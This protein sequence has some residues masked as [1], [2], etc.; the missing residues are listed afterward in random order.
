[1][2]RTL[3]AFTITLA[4]IAPAHASHPPQKLQTHGIAG[5]RN[6]VGRSIPTVGPTS[7]LVFARQVL[8]A[9]P[10]S[11]VRAQARAR[12][13]TI[14]LNRDGALLRPGDNDARLSTSSIVQEPTLLTPWDIDDEMWTETVACVRELYARFD[15]TVTDED[16][17]DV[18]HIEA[19]FGGH[20]TDVGLPSNVAGVSP[21]TTDCGI[22][23]NS[24]V[25]TFTDVLPD[26]PRLMCEVMA[27]EIA[28]SFG[29]DH[30]LLA[31]DP[32]TYLDYPGERSFQDELASCGE[33]T[34]RPCGIDSH[35]CWQKQNSVQLL[36]S[37]LGLR[38]TG[39]P[40]ASGTNTTAEPEAGCQ[41]SGSAGAPLALALAGLLRGLLRGRGRRRRGAVSGPSRTR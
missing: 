41:T 32:M 13:R 19:V 30:E 10:P 39:A 29:A 5:P 24:V 37:R 38:G 27:Q 1:M 22:I 35:V 11:S 31:E 25:F 26:D 12:S 15:V 34:P 2:E 36:G 14:Y 3:V 6:F 16:P 4:A 28:H 17:G 20:P 18:P 7:G 21:F 23:E 40:D 9:P 33:D 8:P